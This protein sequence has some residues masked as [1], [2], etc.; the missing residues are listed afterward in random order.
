MISYVTHTARAWTSWQK[1]FVAMLPAIERHARFAFRTLHGDERA[2]AV[3]AAITNAWLAFVRLA[4]RDRLEQA[5]PTSLA[6]YAVAHV[7]MERTLGCAGNS[8][9]VLSP[10]AHRK[11]G[12]SV[13]YLN[14]EGSWQDAVLE[15]HR[16]P[17]LD[18]VWFRIDFPEWLSG[19]SARERRIAQALARGDSTG[20]VAH[21]Y[22]ITAGRVSQ[23]RRKLHDSW[24][25]FQG[26]AESRLA[27]AP[28]SNALWRSR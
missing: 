1:L 4:Q 3:Q 23:L 15:D 5:F 2:E 9:E 28:S 19:L 16:T 21:K 18:Q 12:F 13:E 17:V 26:E 11:N 24:G 7:R 25:R 10:R 14:D 20:D 8:N 6:R 22:R 27:L